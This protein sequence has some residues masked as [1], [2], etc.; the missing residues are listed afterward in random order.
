MWSLPNKDIIGRKDDAVSFEF[1]PDVVSRFLEKND[2][3]LICRSH[4]IVEDA[5]ESSADRKLVTIL[6]VA[7]EVLNNHGAV[8]EVDESLTC[9]SFLFVTYEMNKI[10]EI[11]FSGE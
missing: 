11:P 4:H 10:C 7:F 5:N 1:G 8:R 3:D 2:Y 6:S 9:G